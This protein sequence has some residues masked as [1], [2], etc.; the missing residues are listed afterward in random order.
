MGVREFQARSLG[1]VRDAELSS[2]EVDITS[3]LDRAYVK[4]MVSG[5]MTEEAWLNLRRIGEVRY[6]LA[7]SAKIAGYA[8]FKAVKVDAS[9]AILR[10]K[11]VGVEAEIVAGITSPYGGVRALIE[12][13]YYLQKVPGEAWLAR[14]TTNL[15]GTGDPDGYWFLSSSELARESDVRA[16]ADAR[17]PIGWKLSRRSAI[18][19]DAGDPLSR[20]IKAED[21]YGR[22]WTPDPE[23]VEDPWSPMQAIAPM[24]RQLHELTETISGRLRQRF[25]MAGILLVPSQI[26][27]AAISGPQ[28]PVTYS[29]DKVMNYLIHVMTTNVVNHASG[30][31]QLPIVLKGD[32][33]VLDKV[34]HLVMDATIAET[35]LALRAE[36]IDRIL[37]ALDQQKQSVRGGEG[38][39]HWGMWAVSDEERRITVQP[40]LDLMCHAFTRMI[41]WR[42]LAGRGRSNRDIRSWR[43][44]YDLS[45]ASVKANLG[46]DGRQ[47]YDRKVIGEEYLRLLTGVPDTAKMPDDEYIRAVG[48]DM[49]NPV[50][51]CHGIASDG[52][53][54]T[55][56]RA[57]LWGNVQP[58]P[59]STSQGDP[60]EV[61]PGVGQPGSPDARDS[62]TP[63]SQEPG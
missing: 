51:A 49:K 30:I 34:R 27:D 53:E 33:G 56:E 55:L 16:L 50:L 46:E 11:S 7:R 4:H 57:A 2:R 13:A 5:R 15:D 48:R 3:E 40:D 59:A 19:R 32:A 28:P 61:G 54:A 52:L 43:V 31:A 29:T 60:S 63:K 18:N 36:L 17:A 38:T 47:L 21:F 6:G 1:H 62:D 10:E 26:T 23:Y 20:Q 8:T 9:G 35:D 39:N 37:T 44:W 58:G 22:V 12:R 42:Q 24:C 45:A 25:A 41:L 14:V